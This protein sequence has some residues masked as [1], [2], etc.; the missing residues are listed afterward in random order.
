M[1]KGVM[2]PRKK[3]GNGT[4]DLAG[5]HWVDGCLLFCIIF[6]LHIVDRVGPYNAQLSRTG[7]R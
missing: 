4:A 6:R 3:G 1:Y 2:I 5:A 7:Q